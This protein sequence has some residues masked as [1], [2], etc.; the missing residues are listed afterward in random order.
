MP[1]AT[2]TETQQ[3]AQEQQTPLMRFASLLNP[4]AITDPMDIMTP[5]DKAAVVQWR[6]DHPPTIKG[7]VQAL[8][9]FVYEDVQHLL[10][11]K[12]NTS[13]TPKK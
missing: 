10:G 4:Y 9:T 13:A 11:L 12:R 2:T 8:G 7:A 1:D 3:R 5:Q 6:K